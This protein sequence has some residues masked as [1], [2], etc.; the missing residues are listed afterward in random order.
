[1]TTHEDYLEGETIAY[2]IDFVDPRTGKIR[3]RVYYQDAPSDGAFG[4]I[5]P[6]ALSEHSVDLALL[7]VG[8]WNTVENHDSDLIINNLRPQEVILGHWEDF[9]RPQ[10]KGLRPAPAQSV[11]KFQRLIEARMKEIGKG[12][13]HVTLPAP[14]VLKVFNIAEGA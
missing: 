12:G 7:C 9:F 3:F 5:P 13:D 8:N 6:E 14:Q 4:T 1:M 10:D 11:R 2:L